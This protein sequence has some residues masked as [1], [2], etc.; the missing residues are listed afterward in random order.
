MKFKI[1]DKVKIVNLNN[2][3]LEDQ[4]E[5]LYDI[6][7][8]EHIISNVHST[9]ELY[10]TI[11]INNLSFYFNEYNLKLCDFQI[12]LRLLNDQN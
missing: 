1:G 8:I 2:T 6:S 7:H 11:Y 4:Q 10:Y 9:D 5:F 3:G 12:K